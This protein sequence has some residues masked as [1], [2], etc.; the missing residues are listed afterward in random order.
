MKHKTEVNSDYTL[1]TSRI[2]WE[3]VDP[4]EQRHTESFR[5]RSHKVDDQVQLMVWRQKWIQRRESMH[6][7]LS[8]NFCN[9]SHPPITIIHCTL[10][11]LHI[12]AFATTALLCIQHWLRTLTPVARGWERWR[13]VPVI[14]AAAAVAPWSLRTRHARTS[15]ELLLPVLAPVG[16]RGRVVRAGD[17]AWA[18]G[19][20]GERNHGPRRPRRVGPAAH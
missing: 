19:V 6:K 7:T 9:G 13:G 20:G 11:R 14:V 17:A 8:W 12:P 18:Q 4:G 2:A 15:N 1:T 3:C 10:H 16:R 5:E